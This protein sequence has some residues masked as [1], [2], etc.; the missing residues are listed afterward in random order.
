MGK[1]DDAKNLLTAKE[2][3]ELERNKEL[4]K[5]RNY[6]E[7]QFDRLVVYLNSGALVLTVGFAKDFAP[8]N[9]PIDPCGES[10]YNWLVASWVVFTASL[11]VILI[12]HILTRK[13]IDLELMKKE[14][15]SDLID[16]ITKYLNISSVILLTFGIISFLVFASRTL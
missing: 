13:S 15:A 16:N 12:S 8:C 7:E 6:A 5:I 3:H 1:K 10:V 2:E 9:E 14:D 11:M 4:L